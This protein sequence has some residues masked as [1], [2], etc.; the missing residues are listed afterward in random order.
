MIV[1]GIN[2]SSTEIW[3]LILPESGD[4]AT[5]KGKNSGGGD[6]EVIEAHDAERLG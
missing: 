4:A 6:D 2:T 5:A 3:V 1:A